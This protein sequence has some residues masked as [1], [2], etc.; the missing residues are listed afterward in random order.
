MRTQA[1]AMLHKL[2]LLFISNREDEHY[3]RKLYGCPMPT[4]ALDDVVPPWN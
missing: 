3:R 2:Q 1:D 4:Q